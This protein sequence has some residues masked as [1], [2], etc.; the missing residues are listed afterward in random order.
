MSERTQTRV[1]KP[2]IALPEMLQPILPPQG[3]DPNIPTNL[4]HVLASMANVSP[5][6]LSTV[7]IHDDPQEVRDAINHYAYV[8]SIN[9]PPRCNVNG[10]APR[11]EP[12]SLVVDHLSFP[13]RYDK[14][15]M[16]THADDDSDSNNSE[17][18]DAGIES[19]LESPF[20]RPDEPDSEAEPRQKRIRLAVIERMESVG[21][22]VL[23]VSNS[24]VAFTWPP[25]DQISAEALAK[26]E[27]LRMI[28]SAKGNAAHISRI[29]DSY[30]VKSIPP[31]FEY[32]LKDS[33]KQAFITF[34]WATFKIG[35]PVGTRSKVRQMEKSV[36]ASA[37]PSS[38]IAA[39]LRDIMVW[40]A[41]RR[42]LRIRER[43]QKVLLSLSRFYVDANDDA[44]WKGEEKK[45]SRLPE[46]I[47]LQ[48]GMMTSILEDVKKFLLPETKKWYY[49]RGLPQRRSFLFYGPPGTGK[50]STI[51]VIASQFDRVCCF[52]SMTNDR[53]SDQILADALSTLPRRALL[54]IEDVDALFK[55]RVSKSKSLTFSGVLNALDGLMSTDGVITVMTTNHI[56][57]LDQALLRAGRVDRQF[58]F[59]PPNQEDIGKLFKS[60][61][62]DAS[63]D[64]V[65]KFVTNI[66]NRPKEQNS[67]SFATLQQLFIMQ[68]ENGPEECANAVGEFFDTYFPRGIDIRSELKDGT[69]GEGGNS[70]NNCAKG[71]SDSEDELMDETKA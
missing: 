3:A 17:D 36:L 26:S 49:S 70:V 4:L 11:T 58:Y 46:S 66:E 33:E 37:H 18:R 60:F 50:T 44:Y 19:D 48:S 39:F 30:E 47:I 21:Q 64:T 43:N 68:R 63:T 7:V 56:E 10:S 9:A 52:L 31:C 29:V 27:I 51:K 45:M 62:P 40:N 15:D 8:F 57:R 71:E 28:K 38:V 24:P 20:R 55:N 25:Y 1:L 67:M 2:K 23:S 14:N 53:F 69:R 22:P 34:F 13:V 42:P 6:D 59:R 5:G 54:V 32:E 35:A 41:Y 12:A 61:Y 65:C 16:K